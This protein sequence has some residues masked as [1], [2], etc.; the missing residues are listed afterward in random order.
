M[1]I[2]PAILESDWAEVEKKIKIVDGLTDWIQ[3][4]VSDGEFAQEKTWDNSKDLFSFGTKSKIEIHLMI[5]EPWFKAE[6]W[7]SS[8]AK[9]ITAHVE[10]FSSPESLKFEEMAFVAQKYGK[11]IVWGFNIE[12]DWVPYKELMQKPHARVLFLGVPAGKQGQKFDISVIDK[13]KSLRLAHPHVKISVDGGVNEYVVI[14]LKNAG[15]DSAVIG[16]D[17]FSEPDPKTSVDKFL[18]ICV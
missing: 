11:E 9:R 16:S 2:I 1:E 8:P 10:A 17:I 18:S 3:I 15:I 13:I 5:K 4:D 14:K 12:T 6:E 7:F